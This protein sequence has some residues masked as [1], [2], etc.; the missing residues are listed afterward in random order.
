[1]SPGAAHS[2]LPSLGARAVHR[3]AARHDHDTNEEQE[4]EYFAREVLAIV[5][6]RQGS[7]LRDRLE[8]TFE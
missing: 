7:N 6:N 1:M 2:L 4:A 8:N 5:S 3:W